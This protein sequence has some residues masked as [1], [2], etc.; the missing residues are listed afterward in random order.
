[1]HRERQRGEWKDLRRLGQVVWEAESDDDDLCGG[2][3]RDVQHTIGKLEAQA[4]LAEPGDAGRLK[5]VKPVVRHV[6][7]GTVTASRKLLAR[8]KDSRRPAR[9]KLQRRQVIADG[10][11]RS[12]RDDL[13]L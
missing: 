6:A 11:G 12:A 8:G 10:L 5:R 7:D 1:M 2:I 13:A 3:L 9:R 4:V